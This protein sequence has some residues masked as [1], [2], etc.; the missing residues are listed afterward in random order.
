M[1]PPIFFSP[2]RKED[3]PRREASPLG[4]PGQKKRAPNAGNLVQC[5]R[6]Y[7]RISNAVLVWYM[8]HAGSRQHP[9]CCLDRRP[10]AACWGGMKSLSEVPL[11]V[12]GVRGSKPRL[13]ALAATLV[14]PLGSPTLRGV[15]R[16]LPLVAFLW[17]SGASR[18]RW[19]MQAQR[20][21]RSRASGEPSRSRPAKGIAARRETHFF[22]QHES[23]GS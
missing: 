23:T 11:S 22:P 14:A 16:T 12:S 7:A 9:Q 3:G 13:T 10:R 2:C 20:L 1:R 21:I 4:R 8:V 15:Q 17:R 18:C 19:Q 6:L 5:E